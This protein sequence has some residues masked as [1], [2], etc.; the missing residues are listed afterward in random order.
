MPFCNPA[1]LISTV[2]YNVRVTNI[3]KPGDTSCTVL[4]QRAINPEPDL[5][6]NQGP[7]ND[8]EP[9]DKY[10]SPDI[11]NDSEVSFGWEKFPPSQ[12]VTV[13]DIKGIGFF[14]KTKYIPFGNGDPI[15]MVSPNDLTYVIHNGGSAPG[16]DFNVN[17][18]TC[19]SLYR[20]QSQQKIAERLLRML[21]FCP[22]LCQN[23]WIQPTWI[24]ILPGQSQYGVASFTPDSTGASRDRRWRSNPSAEN[25]T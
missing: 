4:A 21:A 23:S 1:R 2:R 25:R 8:D 3:S 6:I 13:Q 19:G 10:Q 14:L 11:W 15:S 9:Y 22:L 5:Y 18:L 16:E 17:V 24:Q 12:K 20:L 7:I